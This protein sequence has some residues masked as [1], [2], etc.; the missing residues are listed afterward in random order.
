MKIAIVGLNPG[1]AIY[2]QYLAKDGHDITVFTE[3]QGD[4]IIMDL[5]PHSFLSIVNGES[6]KL[7]T[8]K[9]LEDLLGISVLNVKLGSITINNSEVLITSEAGGQGIR[10]KYDRVVI[11]SEALPRES[12]NCVSIYRATL[13]PGNYVINGGDVGKNVE[14]LMLVADVGGR[15]I[16]NSPMAIDEDLLKSLPMNRDVKA[17]GCVSTDYDV[18][19]PLIGVAG[20]GVWFVGRGFRYR[21]SLSG[22]EY[23]V[24]RDYQLIMMGKLLAMRDLGIIDSLPLMP[25]LEIGFSR[26]WSFLSV[27]LTR[28]ELTSV[29]RDLS[30]SRIAYHSDEAD[31]TAKVIYRGNRLLGLQVLAR[32]IKLLN[33]FSSIYSLIML[34]GTAYL[35]LDMGYETLF[36]TVRG[37]L[38]Q[39]MLNLYNI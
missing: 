1:T 26:N 36:N 39:L 9:Y 13:S 25:R 3:S 16:T 35:L 33:W 24:N 30:S 17:G 20:K 19:K 15:A 14:T 6:I 28:N 32:G 12:G 23:V 21:D 5:L 2:A 38:E 18:V 29:F 22:I 31:I 8:R 37:M 27:G 10:G 34:N 7:F 11:G 4:V